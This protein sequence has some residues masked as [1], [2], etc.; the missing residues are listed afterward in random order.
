[1]DDPIEQVEHR[2]APNAGTPKPKSLNRLDG[3]RP[4][5]V[6]GCPTASRT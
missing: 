4:L 1:M 2:A 6:H 5:T 3:R